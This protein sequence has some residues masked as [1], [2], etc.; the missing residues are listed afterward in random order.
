MSRYRKISIRIWNDEAF[1]KLSRPQPNGQSLFHFCLFGPFTT[2]IPGVFS[3][4]EGAMAERLGWPLKAFREAFR[5]VFGEDPKGGRT[6]PLV[7]ADW[8]AHL[9]Y[10]PNAI[11]YNIPE[12][13]NVI[14]SW[15]DTWDELP[16]C[17]LKVEAYQHL[18]AFL[19]AYSK[20]FAEAF[21]KACPEPSLKASWKPSPNQEQEQEQEEER[22]RGR[23]HARA[24]TSPLSNGQGLR[25]SKPLTELPD[26]LTVTEEDKQLASGFGLNA[27]AL[28]AKFKDH[29]RARGTKYRDWPAAWRNWIRREHEF[30]TR[31]HR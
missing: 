11:K 3:A 15:A 8:K 13:P 2:I 24:A 18:K 16:E 7:K 25:K 28:F 17:Q 1:R 12:S 4:G 6:K 23:G 10:V 19:Q 22:E 30:A 21:L 27:Y 29:H 14:K 31:G 5:E 26:D 20:A 9:V